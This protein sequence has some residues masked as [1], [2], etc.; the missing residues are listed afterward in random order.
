M[1]V[2][3]SKN[4][5]KDLNTEDK[6]KLKEA[7]IENESTNVSIMSRRNKNYRI[8]PCSTNPE[9]EYRFLKNVHKSICRVIIKTIYGTIKGF[10]FLLAIWIE[11]E[12][13]YCFMTNEFIIK[14]EFLY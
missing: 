3:E 8:R 4:D 11:Q 7:D 12:R 13:F 1:G 10:G 2:C 5:N 9:V 6:H 14:K